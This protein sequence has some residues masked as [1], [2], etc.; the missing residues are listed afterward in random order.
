MPGSFKQALRELF[1]SGINP[2]IVHH[3]G[4]VPDESNA[5]LEV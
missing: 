1:Y 2:P 4:A 5:G 3:V